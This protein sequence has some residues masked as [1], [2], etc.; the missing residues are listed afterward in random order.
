MEKCY[1]TMSQVMLHDGSHDEYRKNNVQ[2]I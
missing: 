2:T 1:M